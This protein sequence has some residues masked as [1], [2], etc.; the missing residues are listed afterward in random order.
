MWLTLLLVAG[1]VLWLV[2]RNQRA[3]NSAPARTYADAQAQPISL[4]V[5]VT[6]N[7]DYDVKVLTGRSTDEHGICIGTNL[8]LPLTL[9]GLDA[10]DA[11]EIADAL[12]R[13]DTY[14]LRSRLTTLIASNNVRCK[15]IDAWVAVAKPQFETAVS[16]AI[17]SSAEWTSASELDREDL[18]ADFREQASENLPERPTDIEATLT[19]L[20]GEPADLTVDDAL[21]AKFKDCPELYPVLLNALGYGEKVQV[22]PVGGYNRKEYEAL[23]EIGY[24]RRGTDIPLDAIL[25]TLTLKQMNELAGTDAPKKLTRKAAGIE[26]MKTLPDLNERL[27]KLI[28]FRELF[29]IDV[30]PLEAAGVQVSDLMASY[31]YSNVMSALIVD[32]L[33]SGLSMMRSVESSKGCEIDSWELMASNCCPNCQKLDGKTWKRRPQ[34]LPPFH[35]GCDCE[36]LW[37]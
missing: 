33:K 9:M 32:T 24:V 7:T 2:F 23:A 37:N 28:A 16:K 12:D 21:L 14:T 30:A 29:Q 19:L 10:K 5:S 6:S 22:V 15:E 20:T 1:V 34:K 25:A 31:H 18:L 36:L 3:T 13:Y 26:F 27:S 8:P 11:S 17:A 35:V 4:P